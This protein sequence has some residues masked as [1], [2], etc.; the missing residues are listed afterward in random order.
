M[1]ENEE[2]LVEI[3]SKCDEE[4]FEAESREVK[5][6]VKN[7]ILVESEKA[8]ENKRFTLQVFDGTYYDKWKYKLKLFLEFEEC[9][10]VIEN[11]V[12]PEA[13]AVVEWKK[14]EIKAKK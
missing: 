4:F 11:D 9:S 6:E 1:G 10:E 7:E 14:K 8:S 12:R 13:I 5:K 2:K 3:K